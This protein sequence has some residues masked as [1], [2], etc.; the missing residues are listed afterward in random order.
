MSSAFLRGAV[1]GLLLALPLTLAALRG[2]PLSKRTEIDFF[3]D[4][5][6]RNLK[7]LA[8]RSDGRLVAGPV[9]VDLEGKAPA[10]LLWSLAP[11]R[12]ASR[13]LVGTGPDGKIFE[14]SL[15]LIKSSFTTHERVKLDESHV[16]ALAELSDGAI[17][18]GTSPKGA[19]CLVRGDKIAS[20]VALPVDSIF[21]LLVLSDGNS[22]SY[23]LVA[24]GNP[25]RIYRVDL[26]R[27]SKAGI[28]ADKITDAK[29][30]ADH[31]ISV[32]GEV[33]DRNIRRLA[34]LNDGRV[35]AGSAPRGNVYSF[36]RDGGAPLIL[37][38]NRDAEVTDLLPS[39]DGSFYATLTFS[40]G[41]NEGRITPPKPNAPV[42]PLALIS[43]NADRFAGRSSL[44][45]FPVSGFPETLNA[46]TGSALYRV[47]QYNDT[48]LLTGGEQGE[49]LG[50]QLSNRLSLT[51]SGSSSSQLNGL[52][53]LPGQPGRFLMLRNNAPGFALLDFSSTAPREAET[54][55]LDLGLPS[56]LG[57]L[58]FNRLRDVSDAQVS[59]EVKTSNGSDDLEGWSNWTTLKGV[60][61]GW[62]TPDLRGRYVK[63]RVRLPADV[64]STAELD[65]AGLYAL[66]QNRRPQ[67]QDFHVLST[68]F[69]LVPAPEAPAPSV[70]SVGQVLQ[71]ANGKEDDNKRKNSFLGSQIVPSPGSQ[72]VI[73][74]VLDPD[75]DVIRST[76]SLRRDGDE[77]W[78]D[79]VVGTRDSFAQFD[80]S[81]LADGVYFTRLTA[82]EIDPRPAADR[83]TTV[84]ETDDLIVDHTPPEIIEAAARRQGDTLVVS[85]HGKDALSLLEGIEAV[86]NNGVREQTEQPKDNVRDS[87]D[88]TFVI[89]LPIARVADATSV[90]VLLYDA[91]G[92]TTARRLTW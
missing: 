65:K 44:I 18:A 23:A 2:D 60:D 84:F 86:F 16:F 12:D 13:W 35:I 85:V 25:G 32:F 76:F 14:V 15:D 37:Q 55:R 17:L 19:L 26:G 56:L 88:E 50:Y 79:V 38:E 11:T 89:E 72:V 57:A 8:A 51:Y 91:A 1:R 75:G 78:T 80:V 59:V 71:T 5:P 68:N 54:R 6:S 33:R 29:I 43:S 42:D 92:N 10:D 31:G 27:F 4:V 69:A 53:P 83:L 81:H 7:G 48:L 41:S 61:G 82:S 34:R 90:E 24:T 40:G 21:D 45:W 3:R 77:K 64:K 87:R 39:A 66:P 67:L 70:V 73:W 74:N 49:M 46:R 52:A 62:T 36:S 22:G 28:T 30:L 58:R 47:A 20:R 63:L 9:L